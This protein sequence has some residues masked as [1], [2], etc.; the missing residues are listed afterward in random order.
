MLNLKF[1][2]LGLATAK[3][4]LTIK[5]LSAMQYSIG[6]EVTDPL[7]NVHLR[8]CY[9]SISP[10]IEIIYATETDGPL[11]NILKTQQTAIYHT[12]YECVDIATAVAE[13][14]TAGFRVLEISAPKPAVLFGNRPVAFYMVNGFGL[15]E[16]LGETPVS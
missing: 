8:M 10:A 6:P 15:I 1:H 9:H 12:C 5:Y 14:K 3:P 13:I 7:Q 16:L 4:E 11:Q 2:H